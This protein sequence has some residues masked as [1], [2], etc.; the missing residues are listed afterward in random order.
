MPYHEFGIMKSFDKSKEYCI[1]EPEKYNCISI[2]DD[3]VHKIAKNLR[4]MSSYYHSYT[5]EN[6][7][8]AY[9]GITIIPP[10]SVLIFQKAIVENEIN[11]VNSEFDQLLLIL[12]NA[13]KHDKHIIHFGI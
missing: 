4:Q 2:S 7:G 1:Y 8:L 6:Y 10:N 13:I 12:N 5:N 9:Y 11:S 3:N